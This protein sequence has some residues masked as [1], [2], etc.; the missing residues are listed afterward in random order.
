MGKYTVTDE[1]LTALFDLLMD[2]PEGVTIDEIALHVGVVKRH[3]DDVVHEFRLLFGNDDTVNLPAD[4]NGRGERWLYTLSGTME[5]S[6]RWALNRIADAETRLET[7]HAV[8]ASAERAVDGRSLA[9]RKV[10][11]LR[12]AVQRAREDL[13]DLT[14]T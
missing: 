8:L 7:L 5:H 13:A 10:R 9:G 4:P 2:S 11:I 12:R 14:G 1:Q 6:E 3:A